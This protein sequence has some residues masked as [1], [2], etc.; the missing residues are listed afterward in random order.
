MKIDI[1]LPNFTG[2]DS[3]KVAQIQSYMIQLAKQLQWA[4]NTIHNGDSGAVSVAQTTRTG[5][6]ANGTQVPVDTF[7]SLKSL[8]IKS[9][10]IVNAYY[11]Q[12]SHRMEGQYVATSDFGEY[13]Q[14]TAQAID[15]NAENITQL[16]FNLQQISSAVAQIQE[17]NLAT[18]AYIRSGLLDYDEMGF[19]VYGLEIGQENAAD[20]KVI[21]DKFARFTS[22]RLSF[23]DRNDVEVAYI[24]DYK[25]FITNVHITGTL[26]LGPTSGYAEIDT[27]NGLRI[28]RKG[29]S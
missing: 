11:E 14:Q 19:P 10:D 16:F 21:F 2:T 9:A 6:T 27:S 12:C 28:R 23:F 15:G 24:S 1:R 29:G 8:I 20:G 3:Q 5:G 17:E 25:L 18:K 13:Q 22:G 4:F 7:N 26:L